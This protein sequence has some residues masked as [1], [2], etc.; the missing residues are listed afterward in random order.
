[1]IM[2]RELNLRHLEAVAVAGRLGSISSASQV[3]N[4]SQPALT[5]AVA[6]VEAQLGHLLFVDADHLDGFEQ[7][8][9]RAIEPWWHKH[10]ATI[11]RFIA[12]AIASA[13]GRPPP[14]GLSGLH[15]YIGYQIELGERAVTK[16]QG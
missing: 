7:Q 1:M 11:A 3:M 13:E 6:K 4:L 16:W 10:S 9:A 14:E 15:D 12:D 8:L 2:H 5:Q